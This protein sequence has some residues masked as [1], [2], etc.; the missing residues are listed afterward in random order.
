M[1]WERAV[2]AGWSVAE[3]QWDLT[4]AFDMLVR[5]MVD[6]HLRTRNPTDLHAC[7]ELQ[8]LYTQAHME[9]EVH[10]DNGTEARRYLTCTG[11]RQGDNLGPRLFRG[12]YD[13]CCNT[14]PQLSNTPGTHASTSRTPTTTGRAR[15]QT[16]A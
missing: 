6:E 11:A 16:P 1:V 8:N 13:D 4:K 3:Q 2:R 5:N 9:I 12:P 14:C 7:D 15:R 10:T